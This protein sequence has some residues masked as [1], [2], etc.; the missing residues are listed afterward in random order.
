MACLAV[1]D[2]KAATAMA[3]ARVVEAMMLE[4]PIIIMSP[5]IMDIMSCMPPIIPFSSWSFILCII[6]L[7][8]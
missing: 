5:I 1:L 7:S 4:A 6:L 3:A 8:F 2:Q